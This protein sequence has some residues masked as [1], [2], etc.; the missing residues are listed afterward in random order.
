MSRG[1]STKGFRLVPWQ[2]AAVEAWVRGEEGTR[3][4]GTI[5]VFTGGGK[6]LIALECFRRACLESP[7]AR[8]A[9]V[10]PT[11][12]LVRQWTDFIL[13]YTTIPEQEVGMLG[14]GAR[15]S[16]EE[17]RALVC[18]L[19]SAAQHLPELSEDKQPLMLVVDECHRAGAPAFSRVLD[20]QA[21][22]RLGLSATPEREELD[23][24]GEPLSYDEQ[25][26]GRSLG[27]LVYRF[28]LR[29]ARSIGW[30]P[31]YE[32]HH[33]GVQLNELERRRYEEESRH[34]DDLAEQLANFGI[35]PLQARRAS[36]REGE[37]GRVASAYV[38]RTAKRKDLLYR[39]QERARIATVILKDLLGRKVQTKVLLFHE[40]V[41]EAVDLYERL[42]AALLGV[43][44]GL[45]HSKLAT[46]E[47][48][49][50]LGGFRNGSI[51]VLV[52]VKSLIEGIDVPDADVGI[53]V[54]SSASVRQRI[55]SLGRV[56]RRQF[57]EAE[58]KKEA[59]MHL[60]YIAETV[61]E[62][63]YLKEDW[64]D[65][66][67]AGT[68]RYWLWPLD[69]ALEAESRES[70]PQRPR[71][72][73]EQEWLRV[74]E[75]V[76]ERPVP[77][78]AAPPTGEYSVDVRGTVRTLN[79]ALVSNPQGVAEMV[80]AV[81]GRPG[82]RFYVTPLHRLV[83]VRSEGRRG[84]LFLAGRLGEPFALRRLEPGAQGGPRIPLNPGSPYSGPLDKSHGSFKL[85][86][87]RR[88]VIERRI[89]SR[90]SE[91][92]LV[93]GAHSATKELNAR[94]V[95]AAWRAVASSGLTFHVN[96]LWHAWYL[97]AGEP[98]F[99]EEVQEGFAWPSELREQGEP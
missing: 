8:L 39:A 9:V 19:N 31:D 96:S 37:V 12:A 45:E 59:E 23:E 5:E 78:L 10:A 17:R 73:E 66:T 79:G 27:G 55:Q 34:I 88:G 77:W 83:L 50:A 11:E 94:K 1:F 52:S 62:L 30:L 3:H 60:L 38:A 89:S 35:E 85:S 18:V 36:F 46:R 40:R 24:D 68:N 75:V 91:F 4:H 14:A 47:R 51:R 26:V 98:R 61:D 76:P 67:G 80:Q 57:D 72:T 43:P 99:L 95:L 21:S 44:I 25:L 58:V 63:I 7:G 97:E 41:E 54:A 86:Q 53:S 84:E 15:D 33:H 13:R 2:L 65:L 74:G 82:G 64:S 56:L 28:S 16:F 93:G 69:P 29:E 20:T 90:S 92:A 42:T 49:G 71:P 6:T 81:R 22:F 87:K 48:A 70:P 32:I